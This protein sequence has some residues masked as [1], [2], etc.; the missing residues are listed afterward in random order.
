MDSTTPTMGIGVEYESVY[1]ASSGDR[2]TYEINNVDFGIVE[3]ARQKLD[4][5][6]RVG[7]VK[8]TL[9]NGQV[10]V[11][12]TFD[13]NGNVTGEANHLTHMGPSETASP[14]NGYVRVEMDNELIQGATLEVGYV[15]TTTN[16][17]ELDYLSENYYT[18]GTVE[19]DIV[20][21]TPTAIIDYLDNDWAFDDT[22]NPDWEV[23]TIDEI[24]DIVA[25]V[26]Y[27]N[28]NSTITEK[29]ILYTESLR[30]EKLE[31]TQSASVNLVVSKILTTSDDISID[32][33]AE[34]NRLD[35][36][37]GSKPDEIPGNYIPGTGRTESDDNIAETVIVTPATGANLAFILPISIGI[38]ALVILGVGILLIKRKTLRNK[39][40]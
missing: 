4:L 24:K 16:L 17:S 6:K 18:Y 38:I 5:A 25:D 32:N 13:E 12:A 28:E 29:T 22:R 3:R 1:T 34:I 20:T 21:I 10:L 15:I 23:R 2:Y 8:V 27:N 35:K 40:E 37:G 11:D 14:E 9:A 33:E 30:D 19:G 31:P 26:V 36:T 7:S 39:E